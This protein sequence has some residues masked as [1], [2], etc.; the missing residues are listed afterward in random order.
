[1]NFERDIPQT[2]PFPVF[3]EGGKMTGKRYP[4]ASDVSGVLLRRRVRFKR[5]TGVSFSKG[6]ATCR[7]DHVL[8]Q[9]L[10]RG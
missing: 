1:M 2:E 8:Q 7:G 9:L 6:S 3:K 4:Q 5:I 10:Y